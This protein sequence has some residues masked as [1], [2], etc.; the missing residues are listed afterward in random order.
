MTVGAE[1]ITG[2]VGATR[3]FNGTQPLWGLFEIA[4]GGVAL[5]IS[6][7]YSILPEGLL[8]HC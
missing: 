5:W 3:F 4:G 6:A 2:T 7:G 8:V 1:D